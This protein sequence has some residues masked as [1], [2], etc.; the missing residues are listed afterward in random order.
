MSFLY[1]AHVDQ[2]GLTIVAIAGLLLG[3]SQNSWAIAV[4]SKVRL[5]AVQM[6]SDSLRSS[7]SILW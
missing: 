7:L 4:C 3:L 5:G 2:M 6:S 1:I